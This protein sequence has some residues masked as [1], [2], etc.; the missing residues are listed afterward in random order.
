MAQHASII[1]GVR[2]CKAKRYVYHNN[3]ME[4]LVKK[5]IEA[6]DA[7]FKVIAPTASSPWTA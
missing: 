4:D 5:L 1:D 7:K 2:L 6:K 3:D